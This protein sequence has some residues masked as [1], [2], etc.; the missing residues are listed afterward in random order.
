M[1]STTMTL[2]FC[3]FCGGPLPESGEV[4]WFDGR[5]PVLTFCSQLC[6][7]DFKTKTTR[8]DSPNSRRK[9]AEQ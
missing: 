7:D 9:R 6:C 5:G 1:T 2:R 8:P 4:A 3:R